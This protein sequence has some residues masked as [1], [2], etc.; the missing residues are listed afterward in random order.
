MK[1]LCVGDI[2]AGPGRRLFKTVAKRLREAGEVSAIVVN[3]ENAANGKGVTAELAREIL[4]DGADVVTL[5]DHTWDQK[6]ASA[7]L[8]S[9]RRMV[10]PANYPAACPGRG[11]TS[12]QTDI[13]EVV[14]VNLQGRVFMNP[15]DCPFAKIDELLAGPI[16]R[17]AMVLVDFHAEATSEKIAMG[18]H[19]DGRVSALFGT[20]THVQTSDAKVLPQ[21]MGYITDLGM[22][23]PVNSVI[24]RDV[25]PVLKKF[26]TG[27][28]SHFDI[29]GGPS[30]LEGCIFDID[31]AT[32][33]CKSATAVRFF[34]K[35]F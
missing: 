6:D 16:P 34:E 17:T 2:V 32:R 22:T 26:R 3:A 18:W 23:G 25:T 7:A 27:M 21:G 20:H 24:G 10:R 19:L 9:E 1:I 28:P 29:A 12:F 30:V 13:C 8:E 14:V 4:A 31:R 35:D 33:R 15:T 5:G 11:W